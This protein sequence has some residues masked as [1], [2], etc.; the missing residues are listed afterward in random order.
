MMSKQRANAVIYRPRFHV[1][2]LIENGS[3]ELGDK[4]SVASDLRKTSFVDE[5]GG[6][7]NYGPDYLTVAARGGFRGQ[8]PERSQT[9]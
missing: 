5:D 9:G 6:L 1:L 8:D 3:S 2:L 7:M 4:A